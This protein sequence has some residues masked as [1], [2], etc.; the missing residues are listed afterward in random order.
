MQ[1]PFATVVLY[2]GYEA[3]TLIKVKAHKRVRNGK[4]IKIRS[5]YRH[6]HRRR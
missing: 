2:L 5:Y 3:P 6:T 4:I 1:K